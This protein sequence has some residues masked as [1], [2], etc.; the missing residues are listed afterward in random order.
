MS[1]V[2]LA[3][4]LL[5]FSGCATLSSTWSRLTAERDFEPSW[6]CGEPAADAASHP[7]LGEGASEGGPP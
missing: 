6:D 2:L 3:L 4:I 5:A 1:R 7:D